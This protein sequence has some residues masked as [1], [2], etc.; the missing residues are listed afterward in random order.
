MFLKLK[1][2]SFSQKR[3]VYYQ[4]ITPKKSHYFFTQYWKSKWKSFGWM[5]GKKMSNQAIR[6][7]PGVFCSSGSLLYAVL[8]SLF[9]VKQKETVCWISERCYFETT[10]CWIHIYV[11]ASYIYI[12]EFG[13]FAYEYPANKNRKKKRVKQASKGLAA[14]I[15]INTTKKTFTVIRH[16]FCEALQ[17]DCVFTCLN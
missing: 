8:L 6:L 3:I 14:N 1:K 4:L 13:G 2:C 5:A 17:K 7:K 12:C 9:Q 10:K 15:G 11:R 16:F